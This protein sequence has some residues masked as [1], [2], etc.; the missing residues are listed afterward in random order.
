MR[1][2]GIDPGIERVGWGVVDTVG[3]VSTYYDCGRITTP[4]TLSH[5]ARLEMIAREL[6]AIIRRTQPQCAVV[7]R[8]FFAKNKKTA[9]AVAEARG[10]IMLTLS[11]TS[12]PTREF[13]PMEVKMAVTGNGRAEKKQVAW[14]VRN[15]LKVPPEITSDDTLDALALCLMVTK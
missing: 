11:T 2:L 10:A 5:Q 9:L 4:R 8:L 3:S 1:I 13:T 7:E 12:V 14:M 6:D 15:V